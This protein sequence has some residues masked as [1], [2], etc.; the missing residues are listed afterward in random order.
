MEEVTVGTTSN[1]RTEIRSAPEDLLGQKVIS[2]NAYT[3]LMKLQNK[4]E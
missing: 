1:G 2:K 4:A 3:A